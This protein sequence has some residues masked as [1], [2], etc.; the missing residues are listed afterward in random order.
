MTGTALV[1]VLP[2]PAESVPDAVAMLLHSYADSAQITDRLDRAGVRGHRCTPYGCPVAVYL[3]RSVP[4]VT[5]VAVGYTAISWW[6]GEKFALTRT[7][8][9]LAAW[10]EQFDNGGH[11]TV[12]ATPPHTPEATHDRP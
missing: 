4:D 3:A 12:A 6:R 1:P 10:L 8:R 7:P 11:T 9:R 5:D 2:P